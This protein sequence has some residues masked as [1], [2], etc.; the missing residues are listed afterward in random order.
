[1]HGISI[2]YEYQG[3]EARWE[4]AV[5]GFVNAVKGDADVSGRFHYRVSKGADGKTRVH[6]GWWDTPDTVKALQSKDYF[7]AFAGEI[8]AMAGATLSPVSLTEHLSTE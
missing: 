1:M 7:K 4:A 5:A 8:K 2:R 6:W 3:D